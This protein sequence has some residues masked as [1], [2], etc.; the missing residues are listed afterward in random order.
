MILFTGLLLTNTLTFTLYKCV[1]LVFWGET[2]PFWGE[3][4]PGFSLQI[5]KTLRGVGTLGFPPQFPSKF[6]NQK[7]DYFFPMQNYK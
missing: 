1:V 2:F 6:N 5:K 4:Y 7:D 3:T